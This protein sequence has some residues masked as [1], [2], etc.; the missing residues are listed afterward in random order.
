V[1]RISKPQLEFHQS[2]C[3]CSCSC[4]MAWVKLMTCWKLTNEFLVN[5]TMS[6]F[7]TL[8]KPKSNLSSSTKG[9]NS[10]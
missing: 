5:L 10:S 8:T 1:E 4:W 9:Q 3:S 7:N 6:T 2:C